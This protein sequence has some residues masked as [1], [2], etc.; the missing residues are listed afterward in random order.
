MRVQQRG[1]YGEANAPYTCCGTY[2][3]NK[4]NRLVP[5]IHETRD[6]RNQPSYRVA[7][8]AE[9]EQHNMSCAAPA[10]VILRARGC[11]RR[12]RQVNARTGKAQQSR[13]R[14]KDAERR[15]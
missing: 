9:F 6:T 7:W 10:S 15:L 3:K 8:Q 11:N 14:G 4:R 1:I 12:A 2:K 5:G 13:S